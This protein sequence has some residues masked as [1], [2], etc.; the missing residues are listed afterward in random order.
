[1][2]SPTPCARRWKDIESTAGADS[3]A[4]RQPPPNMRV[5]AVIIL[6]G[7]GITQGAVVQ[8][9]TNLML[10]ANIG[11]KESG[12]P[13]RGQLNVQGQ[14]RLARPKTRAGSYGQ[15]QELYQFE[16]PR[17][18]LDHRGYVRSRQDG[19]L[20]HLSDSR[21]FRAGDSRSRRAGPETDAAHRADRDQTQPRFISST[22]RAVY[23]LPCIGR[24]EVTGRRAASNG[25]RGGWKMACVHASKG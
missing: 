4:P 7:M 22:G 14:R 19:D 3:S 21:Q 12:C 18:R 25:D 15:A 6:Y 13:I 5:K 24:I 10:L 16:P 17:N 23:L 11:K 9:L 2:P 1:M 8:M 20:D